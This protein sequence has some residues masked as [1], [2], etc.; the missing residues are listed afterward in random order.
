M[1]KTEQVVGVEDVRL[2]MFAL[3]EALEPI[4]E[5]VIGYKAKLEAD[6]IHSVAAEQMTVQLHAE[7]MRNAFAAARAGGIA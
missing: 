5:V 4:R 2:Q 7:L 3:A 1:A 6:G